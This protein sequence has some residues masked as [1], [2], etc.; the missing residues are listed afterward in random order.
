MYAVSREHLGMKTKQTI[1]DLA[2]KGGPASK[3]W[4][5]S[6]WPSWRWLTRGTGAR[7]NSGS[8]QSPRQE[9]IAR[10]SAAPRRFARRGKTYSSIRKYGNYSDLIHEV[11][12]RRAHCLC[13]QVERQSDKRHLPPGQSAGAPPRAASFG[14][15]LDGEALAEKK[16]P[17]SGWVN[18]KPCI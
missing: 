17:N 2:Q 6:T 1:R 7:N 3:F 8:E 9:M 15:N 14:L 11:Q 10:F 5:T 18:V 4:S 13:R 12:R 16:T